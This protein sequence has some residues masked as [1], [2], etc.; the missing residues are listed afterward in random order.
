M[1]SKMMVSILVI[2]LAAALIGGGTMAWFNDGDSAAPVTFQ[3]GTLLIDIDDEINLTEEFADFNLEKLNP[4]DT[5]EWE[6]D[7]SNVGTKGFNW[8][9]YVYWNDIIGQLNDSLTPEVRSLLAT[10]GYGD[11]NLSEAL[12]WEVF[13]NGVSTFEGKLPA[14]PEGGPLATIIEDPLAAN[15][16]P[17][18]FTI[19]AN[20]PGEETGNDYQGSKLSLAI[21]V[22]AWQ[23]TNDAPAPT[24]DDIP[25]SPFVTP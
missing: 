10:K 4:G 25:A 14:T 6:F 24:I 21:G 11:A 20:L 8:G 17:V 1:K 16:D 23:T 5:W 3:A 13:V 18:T 7:V 12:E 2:A 15:A 9:I 22:L 19:K